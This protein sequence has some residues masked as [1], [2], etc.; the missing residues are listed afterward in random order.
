[1]GR[2]LSKTTPPWS[3]MAVPPPSEEIIEGVRQRT[4]RRWEEGHG[5]ST[6]Q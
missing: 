1:M 4:K 6:G 2:T 5:K 3:A